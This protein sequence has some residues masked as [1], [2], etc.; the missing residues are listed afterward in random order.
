MST[1]ASGT[2]YI[3]SSHSG[4]GLLN[5][6]AELESRLTGSAP[7]DGLNPHLAREIP[8][9]ST[10]V[11]VLI[12][13]LGDA[14]LAHPAA[15][16][17][18]A[19]RRASL[20][21][22]FPTTTTVSLSTVATGMAPV[23]HGV[24]AHLLWLEGIGRV[25]NTLKWVDLTGTPVAYPT[26]DLLP[27]PN[28][29]ER[30]SAAGIE[31]VTVQPAGF[32][33]TPL[34]AALYRSCRF[35]GAETADDFVTRT[36]AET[37]WPGRFIFTYLPPVDFAAHVY[38]MGSPEYAESLRQ[39]TSIWAA[40]ADRLPSDVV[41]VGTADHGMVTVPETA[42]L[43]IRDDLYRPLEF[44][45]DP[46][47]VMVRGSARLTQRLADETG[48]ELIDPD[49]FTTWLGPGPFHPRLRNRLPDF[50]LLAPPESVILPPGFDKR[51]V[52]YHG[53]MSDNER[54]IP[55][56]VAGNVDRT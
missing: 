38:G 10:V 17:I 40:L 46:R 37:S 28:L 23:T 7:A 47:A 3:G 13:G 12:D 18:R 50:V 31:P 15:A 1:A 45:G 53:G 36:L 34:T 22:P 5:L 14:Q 11:L 44:F 49:R 4:G 16:A 26:E 9:A 6:V 39:V 29:W 56:L 48:A 20:E 41:M 55:L 21:A 24:I 8:R 19:D 30:L 27:A 33:S 32:A 42:K 52:G 54:A 43:L 25:V 2:S 51:L 35:V